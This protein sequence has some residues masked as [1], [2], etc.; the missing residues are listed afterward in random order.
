M[1][2]RTCS[3]FLMVILLAGR[4]QDMKMINGSGREQSIHNRKF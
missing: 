2:F 1:F 3:G 4:L